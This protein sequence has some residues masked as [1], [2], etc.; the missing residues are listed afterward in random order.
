MR[1]RPRILVVDDEVNVART[2]QMILEGQG[3]RASAAYSCAQ[4]IQ[5]LDSSARFDVVLTDMNMEKPES[6]LEVALAAS[7]LKLRPI[8][9]V[10]TGF[11]DTNNMKQALNT[12][13]VDYVIIKP[14]AVEE[15][16]G[17][18]RRL[19]SFRRHASK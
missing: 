17:T 12:H 7:R 2:L 1:P 4:A 19:L 9:I 5:V 8:I 16:L 10:V 15:L 18:L 14:L 11:P 13:A 6:G 3:Y